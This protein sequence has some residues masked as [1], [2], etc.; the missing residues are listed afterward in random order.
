MMRGISPPSGHV[1][2]RIKSHNSFGNSKGFE[3]GDN[4]QSPRKKI[5]FRYYLSSVGCMFV[6]VSLRLQPHRST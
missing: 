5:F 1:L 2:E 3:K 6:C 4:F